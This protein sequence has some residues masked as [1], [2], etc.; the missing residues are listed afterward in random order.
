MKCYWLIV[1]NKY[2]NKKNKK[3]QWLTVSLLDATQHTN[4]CFN[5]SL[6][7]GRVSKSLTRHLKKTIV[8]SKRYKSILSAEKENFVC[9]PMK[10]LLKLCNATIGM[11]HLKIKSKYNNYIITHLAIKSLYSWDHLSGFFIEGGLLL[12]LNLF[13]LDILLIL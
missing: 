4:M 13:L 6:A 10:G 7:C 3:K 8:Y 2:K 9:I 12:K 11:Y 5:I 1:F